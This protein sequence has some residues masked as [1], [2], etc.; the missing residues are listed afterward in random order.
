MIEFSFIMEV[1]MKARVFL[2][3]SL[4]ENFSGKNSTV[5]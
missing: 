3:D 2:G 5:A 4:N 1:R